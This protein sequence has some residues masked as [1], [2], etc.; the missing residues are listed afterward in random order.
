MASHPGLGWR[1]A[2]A[3]VVLLGAL[4]AGAQASPDS[5]ARAKARVD[6]I[7]RVR[8]IAD[9]ILLED[10]PEDDVALPTVVG[11]RQ[12]VSL[13]ATSRGYTIGANAISE[14]LGRVTYSWTSEAF[15]AVLTGSP[16]RYQG[17][18]ATLSGVPPVT[19]RLDWRFAK[20]DTLRLYGRTASSPA[21]LDS[22]QA[23]AIGVVNVST[24]DLEALS[25]GTPAMFGARA[26]MGWE[27]GNDVT[28]G[29]HAGLEYQPKPGGTNKVYWTGTT[30][31]GG[32]ALSGLWSDLNWS[33]G[34]DVSRSSADSLPVAGDSVGRNLFQGGGTLSA[35]VQLDGPLT[36]DGDVTLVVGG[37]FQRPFGAD[38]PDQ[39]NR[40]IPV[41]NTFGMYA[42]VDL[43]VGD[44]ILEPSLSVARES[45]SDDATV[46]R[47]LRYS[48]QAASW[49]ANTGLSVSIPLGGRFELTPEAGYVF[50]NADGTFSAIAGGGSGSGPRR[51]GRVFTQG[52]SSGIRGWWTGV[53]LRVSF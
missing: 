51:P 15:R 31:L 44:W 34:V 1:A 24:V 20:G 12:S 8:A 16:L 3:L 52:F 4:R 38:R 42:T 30:L 48:Y 9:S 45:A 40:L 36:T 11:T 49:T 2:C 29:V 46:S 41:G 23:A 39:P 28:F 35:S 19:A 10:D 21:V 13:Q 7:A 37:W 47:L 18:G 6:S 26:A 22:A 25:L 43:P 53:E 14:V 33:L 50:G 27:L 32:A 5:T 17:N